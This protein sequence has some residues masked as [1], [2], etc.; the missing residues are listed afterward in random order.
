MA[1][2]VGT[3][4][5]T[6]IARRYIIPE[7][8]DNIYNSNV[9]FF[10]MSRANKK[11]IRGGYQIEVPLMYQQ[12]AAG[13]MYQGFDLLDTTP[14]DTTQNGAWDWKQ[15]YVPVTVDG[16]TLIKTD[17]PEAIADFI[18]LYFAQAE[19]ELADVL[20]TSLYTDGTNS[21]DIDGIV[22]ATDDTTQAASSTYA[23][24]DRSSNSWWNG[25]VTDRAGAAMDLTALNT[26]FGGASEGGRHPTIVVSD[27]TQYDRYWDL[28]ESQ[29]RYPSQPSGHDEQL[30]QAGFSNLLLN[31][32]PWVVD[33]HV[34]TTNNEPD[35]YM[36]NEDY[37]YFAAS[38]RA[39]F[40]VEDFQS[41]INQDAMVAK[42]LWAG[43]LIVTNCSRQAR[44]E[45]SA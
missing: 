11:I 32:V 45:D 43:N 33:S 1:T 6:A 8:T 28:N 9:L 21:N 24:I 16:L 12:F 40:Y 15:A 41:A 34:P 3:D 23:G 18:R 37:L 29:Q 35:I 39:D 22:F 36:L 2:P 4:V 26:A 31:G 14:S 7:V 10:R 42:L 27:Q 38:P 25:T 17:S 44:V 13:G 19:M 5:V 30:A 20:G